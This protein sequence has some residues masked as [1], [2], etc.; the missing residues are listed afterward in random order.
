MGNDAISVGIVGYGLAGKIIHA[1]LIANTPGFRLAAVASSRIEEATAD[2]PT[3]TVYADPRDL[4]SDPSVDLVVVASPNDTHR[5]WAR[6]A[7]EAG[8][9]VL[10][11]KPLALTLDEANEIIASANRS[12]GELFVFQNRRFD[13]DYLTVRQ[14]IESGAIG[15]VLHFETAIERFTPLVPAHWT[16]P[17]RPGSGLWYDLG[18]HL[19]DQI[20]Q[21]FGIPNSLSASFARLREGEGAED[22]VEA[23]LSY[24]RRRVVLKL[25]LMVPGHRVRFKVHGDKASLIKAGADRQG[26][27]YL[28][29]NP[30]GMHPWG[31]D[32]DPAIIITPEGEEANIAAVAGD[33][34]QIYAQIHAALRADGP[35]PTPP[36]SIVEVIAILEAG[37]I[38]AREGREV[39]VKVD[40]SPS[41]KLMSPLSDPSSWSSA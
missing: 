8:R 9:H 36:R 18:P 12:Q 4:V 3:A 2:L 7:L 17:V 34:R 29:G 22:W 1:P 6:A 15:D 25:G 27:Q 32:P 35:N 39:P 28:A 40:S 37:I 30:P 20:V 21:L 14:I 13:S 38:S 16:K 31:I 19:I 26:S 11:E 23:I 33:H 5:Y 41:W 10:V 24:D